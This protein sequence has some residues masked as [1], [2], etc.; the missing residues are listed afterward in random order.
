MDRN[1]KILSFD[2]HT[3]WWTTMK[4]SSS[5]YVLSVICANTSCVAGLFSVNSKW[6][7]Y[8]VWDKSG[9]GWKTSSPCTMYTACLSD[10]NAL[11]EVSVCRAF[12]FIPRWSKG[13][14]QTKNVTVDSLFQHRDQHRLFLSPFYMEPFLLYFSDSKTLIL[15]YIDSTRFFPF[16]GYSRSLN[17]TADALKI[18]DFSLW[19]PESVIS[20]SKFVKLIFLLFD[21]IFMNE[22][23]LILWSKK[24][25]LKWY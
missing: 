1:V 5:Q 13:V 7:K 19:I 24:C 18:V 2:K 17:F 20:M 16:L 15:H 10:K 6:A 11:T 3:T 21:V 22:H 12:N 14:R 25:C 4:L 9:K 23:L 8:R